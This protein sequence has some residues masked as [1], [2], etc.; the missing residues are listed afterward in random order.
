MA[1]EIRVPSGEEDGGTD[2][3][4]VPLDGLREELEAHFGPCHA[5]VRRL[6]DFHETLI[7]AIDA[8]YGKHQ[9]AQWEVGPD[10]GELLDE[11]VEAVA[12]EERGIVTA[13]EGRATAGELG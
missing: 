7:N 13:A 1:Y 11:L 8:W 4:E 6:E 10:A 3:I 12:D 2:V 9:D 5:L